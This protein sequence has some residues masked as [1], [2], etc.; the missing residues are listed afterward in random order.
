MRERLG[1][2][3]AAGEG[4]SI[5]L[6]IEE[7]LGEGFAALLKVHCIFRPVDFVPSSKRQEL[8]DMKNRTITK[9]ISFLFPMIQKIKFVI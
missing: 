8:H 9:Y 2:C 3:L 1:Q 7:Y 4:Q 5:T 6:V